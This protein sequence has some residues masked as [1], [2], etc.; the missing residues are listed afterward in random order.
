MLEFE[1]P[2][3]YPDFKIEPGEIKQ[4][5]NATKDLSVQSLFEEIL[6]LQNSEKEEDQIKFITSL[7]ALNAIRGLTLLYPPKSRVIKIHK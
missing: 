6:S 4:P 7:I 5:Q 1:L 3:D 2:P